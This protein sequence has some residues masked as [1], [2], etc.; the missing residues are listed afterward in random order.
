VAPLVVQISPT[1][2]QTGVR[3]DAR[4][5]IT[6]SEPMNASATEAAFSSTDLPAHSY[7]W[8]A[9]GQ[10]LTVTPTGGLAYATGTDLSVSARSYS[11]VIGTGA[12]DRAGNKLAQ[13]F[14][15]QF[16]TFRRLD[17]SAAASAGLS[18]SLSDNGDV[19]IGDGFV[20]TNCLG[21]TYDSEA[22]AF[23]TFD[24]APLPPGISEFESATL[25]LNAFALDS[26]QMFPTAP[27]AVSQVHFATLD[28]DTYMAAAAGELGTLS[29]DGDVWTIDGATFRDGLAG[30]YADRGSNGNRAQYRIRV[31]A[32]TCEQRASFHL[33]ADA[34]DEAPKLA[35]RYL[36]P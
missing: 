14:L 28:F 34:P 1:D 18:G 17:F 36:I 12:A 11:F 35:V 15:A 3:A 4:L 27:V 2:G 6:F 7:S 9:T 31:M 26:G 25:T 33:D 5:V 21:T 16:S 24:I 22:R 23:L 29:H 10:V 32:D 13:P 19:A 20:Y 8:D 30:D